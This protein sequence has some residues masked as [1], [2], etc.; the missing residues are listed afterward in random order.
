MRTICVRYWQK[1]CRLKKHTY[2]RLAEHCSPFWSTKS[3]EA[4]T[5]GLSFSTRMLGLAVFKENTL[6]DYFLKLHK[7][8]WSSN[9]QE[10]ILAS[11][12]SCLA[13]YAIAEVIMLL[14][15]DHCQTED[16][17]KLQS[18]IESFALEKGIQ[19]VTYQATDI[20]HALGNPIKRT[21]N[22]LMRRLVS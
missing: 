17:K 22:A 18:A 6:V 9:K 1:S 21:R 16:F 5:L 7:A 13:H 20:Y 11:I 3:M 8:K 4:I 19:T 10:L 15:A 14:P 12:A 2:G